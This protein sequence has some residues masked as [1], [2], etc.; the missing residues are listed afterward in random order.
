VP[1]TLLITDLL[2]PTDAPAA[3][4]EVR[5]PGL[6]KALG[7]ADITREAADGAHGW[8]A[9]DWGLA[10][11]VPYAAIALAGDD[12]A[13]EGTWMRADPVH[14]RIERDLVAL[15]DASVLDVTAEEST[16]LVAALQALFRDDGLEFLAAAPE[17]WYVRVPDADVPHTTALHNAVGRDIFALL[18]RG[19]GPLNWRSMIT[20]SQM[21]L[22]AHAANARRE[23]AGQPAVNSVWFWGEGKLPAAVAPRYAQV[24]ADDAFARGLATLAGVTPQPVPERFEGLAAPSSTGDTLVVLDPLTRPLR[25]ADLE[26]WV[27]IAKSLDQRWFAPAAKAKSAFGTVRVVLTGESGAVVAALTGKAKWRFLNRPRRLSDHA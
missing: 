12:R 22:S 9:N 6:E 16:A 24:Y 23:T 15:H 1:L 25:R 13:R 8:L 3:V 26:S 5:L 27:A 18:P 20:E 7:R 17:R 14:L 11:P 21:V 2:P 19:S 4:R 10:P